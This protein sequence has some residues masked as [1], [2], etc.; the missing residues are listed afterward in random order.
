MN[1]VINTIVL[2]LV[3]GSFERC[4]RSVSGPEYVQFIQDTRNG[5]H[6]T[7]SVNGWD[8]MFQYKPVDYVVLSEMRETTAADYY[9]DRRK[10]LHGTVWFNISFKRSDNS[11]SPL[12][13]NLPDKETYEKRVDHFLNDA[14]HDVRL[15]YGGSDTLFPSAYIFENNY[16]LAPQETMVVGFKLP[17][18]IESP[19]EQMQISYYD[20][21]FKNGIIKATFSKQ[22]INS[23]PKLSF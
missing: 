15:V 14:I 6:K 19:S 20:R 23:I 13:Y 18:G 7:V 11:K 8:F 16:N 12:R 10:A 21:I 17:N 3:I 2:V 22:Q 9:S 1:R 5:L 4:T